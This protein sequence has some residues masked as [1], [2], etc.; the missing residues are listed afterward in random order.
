MERLCYYQFPSPARLEVDHGAAVLLELAASAATPSASN[1]E[2]VEGALALIGEA[3]GAS[4]EMA[5]QISVMPKTP[6]ELWGLSVEARRRG[7]VLVVKRNKQFR[8]VRLL[9]I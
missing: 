2:A 5:A 7:A 9:E 4:V 1:P 8:I 3:P 6:S